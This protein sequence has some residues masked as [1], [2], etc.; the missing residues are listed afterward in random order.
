[1][2]FRASLSVLLGFQFNRA[3]KLLHAAEKGEET[4]VKE[5]RVFPV[6][7]FCMGIN[8]LGH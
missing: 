1:M 8:F 7:F 5:V 2:S 4:Q 6:L 3:N